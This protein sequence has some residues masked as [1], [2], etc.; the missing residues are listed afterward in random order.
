MAIY[1]KAIIKQTSLE[2]SKEKGTPSVCL[3]LELIPGEKDGYLPQGVEPSQHAHLWLT[4]KTIERTVKTL[5][6]LG[7]KGAN[8]EDLH[9]GNPLEGVE[10]SITGEFETDYNGVERF[11]VQ[12]VNSK[13]RIK[14]IGDGKEFKAFN[15]Y[16]AKVDKPSPSAAPSTPQEQEAQDENTPF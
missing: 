5:R 2:K 7:W 15:K 8:F 13:N 3:L 9:Y 11:R 16:L 12:W 4:A 14:D 10:C 6:E 1:I